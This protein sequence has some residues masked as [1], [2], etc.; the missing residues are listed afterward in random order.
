MH[1]RFLEDRRRLPNDSDLIKMPQH[2]FLQNNFFYIVCSHCKQLGIDNP[3][4][5]TPG[6]DLVRGLDS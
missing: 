2:H 6:D 3:I 1:P 4:S 5:C